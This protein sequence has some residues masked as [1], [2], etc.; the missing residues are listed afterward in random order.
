MTPNVHL[1][2]RYVFLFLVA[3]SPSFF[4]GNEGKGTEP[5]GGNNKRPAPICEGL[6]VRHDEMMTMTLKVV[7]GYGL[8]E[9]L[10]KSGE[11]RSQIER[12]KDRDHHHSLVHVRHISG[13]WLILLIDSSIQSEAFISITG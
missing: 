11:R 3:I 1:D 6:V 13:C 2:F 9:S 5:W 10:K 8:N 7:M 12:V 4:Q